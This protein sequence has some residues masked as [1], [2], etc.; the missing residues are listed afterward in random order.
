MPNQI[1]AYDVQNR[2]YRV[3]GQPVMLDRDLAE[4]Y[5]VPTKSL[6]LAVRRNV[7]RFPADFMFQLTKAEFENLRFQIETSRWGG[8][9]YPPYAFTQEGVAMLANCSKEQACCSGKHFRF[10]CDH[11]DRAFPSLRALARHLIRHGREE[12]T[13]H[14]LRRGPGRNRD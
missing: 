14:D 2:I 10:R 6:N 7:D 13:Q 1:S 12:P 4:L 8:R 3:R 11:C 9:R 5:Q